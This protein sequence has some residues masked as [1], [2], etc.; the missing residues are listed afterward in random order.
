MHREVVLDLESVGK[1]YDVHFVGGDTLRGVLSHRHMWR[2]RPVQWALRDVSFSVRR[3]EAV[4]LVGANGS[5][6]STLLRLIAG[7]EQPTTGRLRVRGGVVGVLG[8]GVGFND[9]LSGE[10]NL[11]VAA[12]LLGLSRA[13]LSRLLPR[14]V[15]FSELGRALH[16]PL[17]EYSSGMVARLGFALAMHVPADILLIDEVLAVGDEAFRS[18]CIDR[19]KQFRQ[20]GGSLLFASHEPELVEQ[21]ADRQLELRNGLLQIDSDTATARATDDISPPGRA[22]RAAAQSA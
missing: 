12:G 21:L 9:D 2:P 22:V 19:V 5:G 3:G 10:Q 8:L 14:I 20:S 17:R 6:K 7:V 4:A 1:R 16:R 18:R 15:E 13:E 11:E